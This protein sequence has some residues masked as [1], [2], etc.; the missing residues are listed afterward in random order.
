MIL[1]HTIHIY[2]LQADLWLPGCTKHDWDL[3]ERISRSLLRRRK[4]T[5]LYVY[6]WI[7]SVVAF[8]IYPVYTG[9]FSVNHEYIALGAGFIMYSA[10]CPYLFVVH[11]NARL[12]LYRRRFRDRQLRFRSG[13]ARVSPHW[14]PISIVATAK[15]GLSSLATHSAIAALCLFVLWS[16][17]V[18]SELGSPFRHIGLLIG[19]FCILFAWTLSVMRL[20]IIRRH[21]IRAVEAMKCP[22]CGMKVSTNALLCPE[23]TLAYPLCP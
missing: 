12:S 7:S 2:E 23:C 22:S 20:C 11:W 5:Y 14:H 17:V 10:A 19:M 9:G 8:A 18:P 3:G 1:H 16:F 13:S 6:L 15:A 21:T 4:Y